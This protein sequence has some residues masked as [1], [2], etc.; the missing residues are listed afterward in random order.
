MLKQSLS[1][2][3]QNRQNHLDLILKIIVNKVNELSVSMN[4]MYLVIHNF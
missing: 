2:I 3:I 1:K 4:Q